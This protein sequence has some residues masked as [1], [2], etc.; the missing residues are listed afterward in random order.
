MDKPEESVK[1]RPGYTEQQEQQEQKNFFEWQK[2]SITGLYLHCSV[3]L[4][5]NTSEI[6]ILMN[7][8]LN[9]FR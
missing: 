6:I 9:S 8:R 5:D 1:A 2:I 7:S 3:F 4:I